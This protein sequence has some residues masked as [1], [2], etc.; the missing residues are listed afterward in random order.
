MEM[1]AQMDSS[2]DESAQIPVDE[3]KACCAAL[4]AGDL[5]RLLLGESFHP[6]GLAL[7]ERLGKL[8]DLKPGKHVLDVAAG[9][10]TSA[11]FL[12]QNFGCTVLGVEYGSD[13]VREATRAAEASGLSHL[14]RFEQG[15][16][17][18]LA[19]AD[20]Q[21]DAVIC[22]CAFCT[23]P[24]KHAAV[25]EFARV[26]R[27]GGKVGLTDLT[28]SGEV[29]PELQGLLAWIA[30]IAAAREI[31]EYARYLEHADFTV[32]RIEPHDDVLSAMVHDIRARLFAAELLVKLKQID[33]PSVDFEQA[34]SLA[35][36]A[37]DAVN[38]RRFGYALFI[39]TKSPISSMA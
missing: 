27:P 33:L 24:N 5:A 4:Y 21:F 32:D 23:F 13:S 3:L 30:C 12:A 22:E 9:R 31:D 34:R 29:P 6:G 8:L 18:C 20:K 11:I 2:T 35:R 16:A 25:E 19:S 36:T 37:A 39:A 17:E 26:L 10:G 28:R 14:V 38:A 1:D 7:T 15:D